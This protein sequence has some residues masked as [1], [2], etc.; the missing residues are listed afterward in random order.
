[1]KSKSLMLYLYCICTEITHINS[2]FN[3]VYILSY[4]CVKDTIYGI[5]TME[6]YYKIRVTKLDVMFII[7]IYYNHLVS[8]SKKSL[9]YY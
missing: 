2:Y 5:D 6:A 4:F 9:R 1:M 3:D 8:I 7:W